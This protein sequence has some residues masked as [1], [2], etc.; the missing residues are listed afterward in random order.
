MTHWGNVTPLGDWSKGVSRRQSI[1]QWL[2]L[3]KV[4]RLLHLWVIVW[5]FKMVLS[6]LVVIPLSLF[7]SFLVL[8]V[9]LSAVVI[10]DSRSLDIIEREWL[11]VDVIGLMH[12]DV[13]S[14]VGGILAWS[15]VIEGRLKVLILECIHE[16]LWLVEMDV[17]NILD[18][19]CVLVRILR[20]LL[21]VELEVSCT[22]AGSYL[23]LHFSCVGEITRSCDLF[24]WHAMCSIWIF[25]DMLWYYGLTKLAWEECMLVLVIT[26]NS[27]AWTHNLLL[28]LLGLRSIK[29]V[30]KRSQIIGIWLDGV[31]TDILEIWW[32]AISSVSLV[33]W[34]MM[35]VWWTSRV[36]HHLLLAIH[37]YMWPIP[38]S[39]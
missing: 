34:W 26:V 11:L 12:V 1:A 19:W 31:I 36:K 27:Q 39:K 33:R 21:D 24:W 15:D 8:S 2:P 18:I 10:W 4:E 25:D 28:Y 38:C 22:F 16:M 23:V 32:H 5:K 3:W 6:S 30:L 29:R 7:R 17:I 35:I 37:L 20:H 14:H 13:V 9:L